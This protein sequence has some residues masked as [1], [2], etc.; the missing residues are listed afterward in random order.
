MLPMPVAGSEGSWA[1]K[2]RSKFKMPSIAAIRKEAMKEAK[3]FMA[4]QVK[5]HATMTVAD[6]VQ[7]VEKIMK[8]TT[9][10][11]TTA[12]RM[13][14]D[15]TQSPKL[16]I[17]GTRGT[18]TSRLNF[19]PL[20]GKTLTQQY[21]I[22]HSIGV[23]DSIVI[24]GDKNHDNPWLVSKFEVQVGHGA[25]WIEMAPDGKTSFVDGWWLDGK[26]DHKGPYYRM[27]HEKRWLLLPTS[28]K[29]AYVKKFAKKAPLC[30]TLGCME[31]KRSEM[32]AACDKRPKC[33]GFTFT[34]GAGKKKK[35]EGCLKYRCHRPDKNKNNWTDKTHD[36]WSKQAFVWKVAAF[37]TSQCPKQCAYEGAVFTGSRW[38]EQI[39]D[40]KKVRDEKCSDW[41]PA[42]FEPK[43][44]K[45]KCPKT[46]LCRSFFTKT[47]AQLGKKC[48]NRCGRAA[49]TLKGEVFCASGNNEKKREPD[50]ACN[51]A[52]EVAKRHPL[53]VKAEPPKYIGCFKDDKARNLRYGPGDSAASHTAEGRR[54]LFK[55][56]ECQRRCRHYK[57]FAL[58]HG[59][60][61]G[62]ECFC[63]NTYGSPKGSKRYPKESDKECRVRLSW[64][65]EEKEGKK[66]PL[67]GGA[68]RNAVY[69][70]KEYVKTFKPKLPELKCAANTPCCHWKPVKTTEG[71]GSEG[72]EKP[73]KKIKGTVSCVMKDHKV[74]DSYCIKQ[75]NPKLTKPPVPT[76]ICPAG[77]P[78]CRFGD[79]SGALPMKK[80]CGPGTVAV[81]VGPGRRRRVKQVYATAG[82]SSAIIY[83][84][85]KYGINNV[86]KRAPFTF[87]LPYDLSNDV[88]SY[89]VTVKNSC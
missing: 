43:I 25:P 12:R 48:S 51:E 87:S 70:N 3:A 15:S 85:D 47:P 18:I 78:C 53:N 52:A 29:L 40:G 76:T 59:T 61:K 37:P 38:C 89:S 24:Y 13:F 82:C 81:H 60:L 23:I 31:G 75:A 30:A 14:A 67:Y 71:C 56:K 36:Y 73:G 68:W 9:I 45:T 57:F 72:C 8:G 21:H 63:S 28:Q 49:E 84:D 77:G 35:G 62:G 16:K 17:R 58:Q 86:Q 34:A 4:L 2:Q 33:Q 42:L 46:R 19:L 44:P 80:Y 6:I 83:D 79:N 55:P 27:G 66:G 5:Q 50:S 54:Q 7:K 10:R 74:K 22:A 88:G 11:V 20:G 26:T 32:E 41:R 65:E 64:K 1:V 39:V 69:R